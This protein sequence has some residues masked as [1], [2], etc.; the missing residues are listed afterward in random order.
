VPSAERSG[1]YFWRA[2]PVVIGIG[3]VIAAGFLAASCLFFVPATEYALVTAFGAPVRAITAPGIYAKLPYHLVRPIDNRLFVF[4]PSPSEFLTREKTPVIASAALIWRVA[5]PKRYFETVYDRHGAESRLGDI[6]YAELGAAIGGHGLDAFISTDP[7]SYEAGAVLAAVRERCA[8]IA[9]RD[10]GIGLVDLALQSFDF[11]KQN[12]ERLYA[13]M[14]S[15]RAR[16]SMAYRS[17]GEE[18]AVKI[19]A[20]AEGERSRL[21][22]EALERAQAMRA[23]G[24]GEASRISAEAYG[25]APDFYRFLRALDASRRVLRKDSTLVLPADTELFGLLLDSRWFERQSVPS[26][27][28]A[29]R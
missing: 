26:E 15:E 21:L 11:P 18:A 29:K 4:V 9:G 20:A 16:L 10:Y 1:F 25:A 22:S 13:R 5:D 19:G 23:E 8:E 27:T 6:L 3:T 14:K 17:E 24:D 7:A 2:R 28:S 12:R